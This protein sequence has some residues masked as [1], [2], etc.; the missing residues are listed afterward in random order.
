MESNFR[1]IAVI[2]AALIASTLVYIM[3]PRGKPV[4]LQRHDRLFEVVNDGDIICRLGEMFWSRFF[5]DISLTD[6]RFSH[7]GIIR[8]SDGKIS[9]IHAE[10]TTEPG[11]DFVKEEKFE[12]FIKNARAIGI[13]RINNIEGN[14]ISD[15]AYGYIGTPFDWQFDMHNNSELY[16]TELLYAVLKRATPEL[17]LNTIF[18]KDEKEIIP[19]DAVSNSGDF[20]EVYFVGEEEGIPPLTLTKE[21]TQ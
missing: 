2:F 13:Y 8:I 14:Q 3:M 5:K 19:I 1:K 21:M 12:D 7:I 15:L 20:S 16:C 10:G 18:F 4:V 6:K 17:R 11:K 9:V